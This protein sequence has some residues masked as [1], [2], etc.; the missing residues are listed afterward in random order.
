MEEEE[1]EEE[2]QEQEE[3]EEGEGAGRVLQI[4]TAHQPPVSVWL[5]C[6]RREYGGPKYSSWWTV[7]ANTQ[8]KSCC[9]VVYW[10]F[11][12]LLPDIPNSDTLVIYMKYLNNIWIP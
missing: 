2:E 5:Y 3:E 9:F 11:L 8:T 7:R 4:L 12:P 1:E 10:W 6:T